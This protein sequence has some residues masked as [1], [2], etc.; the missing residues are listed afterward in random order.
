MRKYLLILSAIIL[1]SCSE[2]SNLEEVLSVS[3]RPQKYLLKALAGE[4]CKI[5]VLIPSGA[6]PA[7]YEPTTRQMIDVAKSKAYFRIGHIGFERAWMEKIEKNSPQTH[8]FDSS[9]G[10]QLI[11]GK[12]YKHGNH[13]HKAGVEPHIWMSPKA[14]KIQAQNIAN[15]LISINKNKQK[16]YLKNLKKLINKI[17]SID[18]Y[19]THK[20]SKH[21]GKTFFIFHPALTYFARDYGLRQVAI[22]TEGKSPSPAHLAKIVD[23]TRNLN[24]K[25]IFVQAEFDTDNAKIIAKETNAK[26]ITIDPLDENWENQMTKIA[27]LLSENL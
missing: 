15:A 13:T 5:N 14:M 19:V 18:K 20:L 8:F 7:T 26:I 25:V 1:T 22:E 16:F 23:E 24:V 10:V 6:S 27:N 3:V 12:A 21:K 2:T 17:D 11:T 9:E 4:N